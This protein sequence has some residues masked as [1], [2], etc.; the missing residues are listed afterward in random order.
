M[1][2]EIFLGL[3]SDIVVHYNAIGREMGENHNFPYCQVIWGEEEVKEGSP[4]R[5]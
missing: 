4:I 2:W 3:T 5:L 1:S